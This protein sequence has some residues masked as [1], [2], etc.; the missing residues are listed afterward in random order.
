MKRFAEEYLENW[1]VRKHRKPLILRG[2]RQV[3][4]STLV[5]QF[6][7]KHKLNLIEIN[8]ERNIYLNDLFK[9]MD[10]NKIILELEALTGKKVKDEKSLIF[11]DEIQATPFALP[12]LRYFYED[13][14]DIPVI[15]AGSL[16]EFT[17]SNHSFSM[18]VGRIEYYHLYPMS[19]NEF[20]FEIY[21]ALLKYL[22]NFNIDIP[23]PETAHNKL[24]QIQREYLFVGGMPEAVLSYKGNRSLTDVSNVH[25]SIVDTFQDDFSK[26]ATQKDLLLLQKVFNYIPRSLG[27][28]IKYSNISREN[29]SQEIKAIIE[30]LT[31][32]RICHKITHSYASGIP[33]NADTNELAY[34]LIFMDIGLVNHICGID[35]L[36]I[37]SMDS[38]RM[39][40]EG[41]LAEQFIGQHLIINKGLVKP[42]LHYWIRESKSSNAEID[43]LISRGDWI[44]P[45]EVKAGKSGSLK[46]LHQFAHEK[47]PK[48]SIRFDLNQPGKQS[49]EHKIK[50]GE[51]YKKVAFD[52]ISLP[53]YL[54]EELPELID[55]MRGTV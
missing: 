10:L 22:I 33:L 23:I 3:G 53:L 46:S 27:K 51:K 35:W 49:I 8:L 37:T 16:L 17:L 41:G 1:L 25:R 9:S 45:I 48:I 6:A 19:F 20:L 32:A 55:K 44:L 50:I 26:Y 31:K 43:Y 34:K 54:V 29:R 36:S 21:P 2:A 24:L 14:P 47:K 42:S 38:F 11:L 40:N 18:P 15:A 28:K 13:I 4:K 30:L 52:L 12:A 5:R 7:L 39:I